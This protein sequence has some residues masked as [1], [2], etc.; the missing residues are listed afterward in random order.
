MLMAFRAFLLG[1]IVCVIW[2]VKIGI[3]APIN[4][5]PGILGASSG[6]G[7]TA[8]AATGEGIPVC[9]TASCRLPTY[10]TTKWPASSLVFRRDQDSAVMG[11]VGGR[12]SFKV[13]LTS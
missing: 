13:W 10:P 2:V 7:H 5:G 1:L 11:S 3:R 8:A 4:S 9:M 6:S 12:I